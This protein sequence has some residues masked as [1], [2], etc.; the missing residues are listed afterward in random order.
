[1]YMCSKPSFNRHLES[2]QS[3]KVNTSL[4]QRPQALHGHLSKVDNSGYT[5][6]LSDHLSYQ[7]TSTV[8]NLGDG[9]GGPGRPPAIF[10]VK[11]RRNNRRYKSYQGKPQLDVLKT[12]TH[13]TPKDTLR[14]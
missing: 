11:K 2:R 13:K 1:M 8:V 6:N 12:K 10:L 5:A 9:P 7:D 14:P 4:Q 3:Y